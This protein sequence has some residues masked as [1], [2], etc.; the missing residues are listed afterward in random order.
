M[1]YLTWLTIGILLVFPSL[2]LTVPKAANACLF[3]L[4]IFGLACIA[5]QS[6]KKACGFFDFLKRYWPVHLSMAGLFLATLFNQLAAEHVIASRLD[7]PS[8]FL[9][10]PL[11]A[12]AVFS[13]SRRQ[14]GIVQWGLAAGA[15]VMSANIALTIYQHG[16]MPMYVGFINRI[17]YSGICLLLGTLSFFSIA[18]DRHGSKPV[19]VLK[20]MAGVAGFYGSILSEVRG[21]WAAIPVF[22]LIML[23]LLSHV[24]PLQR[25]AILC[26]IVMSVAITYQASSVVQARVHTAVSDVV[27]YAEGGNV[28]T[29]VGIRF[30]LWHG[31]VILFRENPIFGIGPERLG[32]HGL[33]DLHK[34]G[35]LSE[36][37]THFG[38][39]HN[40]LLH[41]TATLG[42]FG[43][44]AIL[45]FYFVPAVY[46]Y[47]A[48]RSMDRQ[49]RTAAGMGL[50]VCLGFFV[51]GLTET[52][53]VVKATGAFY[54][55]VIAVF[56]G[57][58]AR[59]QQSASVL[60]D[61]GLQPKG[62]SSLA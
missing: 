7:A 6:R 32:S 3:L 36:Q 40:D 8:R 34:R 24:R 27:Q 33:P 26:A 4:A 21:G 16:T 31:S 15:V 54:C 9:L 47:A 50:C 49:V 22:A 46:F 51:F 20:L 5:L 58:V 41:F 62:I 25:M 14:L 52:M 1:P 61:H 53:F 57:Y 19:V 28:D 55:V 11:V 42:I 30:Q 38:H 39:A 44:L 13:L 48:M 17:P 10:F 35:L 37:A 12:W 29:S 59:H 45:G 2:A 23:I 43:M 60:N 56:L 18:L